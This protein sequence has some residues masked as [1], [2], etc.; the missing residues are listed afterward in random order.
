MSG[1][2]D[3]QTMDTY[4]ILQHCLANVL[5]QTAKFVCILDIVEETLSLSLFFQRG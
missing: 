4:L 1:V 5:N 2:E 3:R